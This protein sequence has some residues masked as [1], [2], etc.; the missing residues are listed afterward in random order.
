[1]VNLDKSNKNETYNRIDWGYST[2]SALVKTILCTVAIVICIVAISILTHTTQSELYTLLMGGKT[3]EVLDVRESTWSNE[4]G[5]HSDISVVLRNTETNERENITFTESMFSVSELYNNLK[6]VC[7]G[8][9][10]TF[11]DN[12]FKIVEDN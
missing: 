7:K 11:E 6:E 1:M 10:I 2:D 12:K 4:G 5:I 3:F 9:I 8:D